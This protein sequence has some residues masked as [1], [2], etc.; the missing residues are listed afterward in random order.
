MH[1][2]KVEN[3][4]YILQKSIDWMDNNGK[5]GNIFFDYLYPWKQKPKMH[6]FKFMLLRASTSD[7]NGFTDILIEA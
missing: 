1:V 5:T 4:Y 2:F 3:K 6:R 7:K